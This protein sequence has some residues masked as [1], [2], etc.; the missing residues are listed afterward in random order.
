MPHPS[1]SPPSLALKRLSLVTPTESGEFFK[2]FN[3]YSL[4]ACCSINELPSSG[5]IES[6]TSRTEFKKPNFEKASDAETGVPRSK[7][8]DALCCFL[9]FEKVKEEGEN[10]GQNDRVPRILDLQ[11]TS[12]LS[13]SSFSK[14]T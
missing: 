11:W 2:I 9:G 5:E 1:L 13:L 12:S 10:V 8:S 6:G 14:L 3:A 7:S 4:I